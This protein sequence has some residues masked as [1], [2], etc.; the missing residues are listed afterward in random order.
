[1]RNFNQQP[2]PVP[3]QVEIPQDFPSMPREIIE[4]FPEAQDWQRRLDD[5]WTRTNQAIQQSQNQTARQINQNV[6]YNVDTFLIYRNGEPTPMFALDDTGIR[7]GNVLVVNTPGRKVYI[8]EGKYADDG[9]PFYIDTLGNFSLGSS[10]S[11]DPETDTLTIT[12]TINANSGTIGGFEIGPDYIRDTLNSF[13]LA[14][15]VTGDDD[16]RFWAGSSFAT[17][18]AAPLRIYESGYMAIT[19]LTV[20]SGVYNPRIALSIAAEVSGG[21][22]FSQPPF[23]LHNFPTVIAGAN[24]QN[25]YASY[26]TGR[27]SPGAFTGLSGYLLSVGPSFGDGSGDVENMYGIYIDTIDLGTVTNWGLYVATTAKSFFAGELQLANL[28]GVGTRNVVVDASGNL[29]AP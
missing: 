4:R 15:T 26:F 29:S 12:G 8:G 13:G 27:M 11:W 21:A 20:G 28:A 18:D 25:L 14:S 3:P 1:M 23:A 9:T 2:T 24:N 10:L 22:L 19:N 5:F 7:L 6:I 16:V 17:R